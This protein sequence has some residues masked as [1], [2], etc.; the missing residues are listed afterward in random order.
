LQPLP[1][2]GEESTE[3]EGVKEFQNYY[4]ACSYR[5]YEIANQ[6]EVPERWLKT[7]NKLL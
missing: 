2:V 6:G 3:K 5:D 7:L 4:V 1:T